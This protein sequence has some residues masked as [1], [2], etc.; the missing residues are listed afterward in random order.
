M[1]CILFRLSI[2]LL[3]I[4]ISY[5]YNHASG[6]RWSG[7]ASQYGVNQVD[8]PDIIVLDKLNNRFYHNSE[9]TIIEEWEKFILHV[10][11]GSELP[12]YEGWKGGVGTFMRRFRNNQPWSSF[13]IGGFLLIL[14]FVVYIVYDL[15]TAS[16]VSVNDN[17]EVD[18]VV[19]SD[20]V[21]KTEKW[22]SVE[23]TENKKKL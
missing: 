17:G 8:L 4:S 22:N 7:F 6:I 16:N 5:I 14:M 20:E 13:I 10:L 3:T 23:R 18:D 12:Q 2:S 21:A 11:D 19:N 1:I 15:C 9:V